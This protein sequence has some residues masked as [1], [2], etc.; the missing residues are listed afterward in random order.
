[1]KTYLRLLRKAVNQIRANSIGKDWTQTKTS[2]GY[3]LKT[4]Y[5]FGVII[6]ASKIFDFSIKRIC[7][8]IVFNLILQSSQLFSV[9][10]NYLNLALARAFYSKFWSAISYYLYQPSVQQIKFWVF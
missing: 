5:E 10:S 1:M 9:S 7:N 8:W 3:K 4:W 2:N 6:W